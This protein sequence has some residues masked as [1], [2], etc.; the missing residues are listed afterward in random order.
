SLQRAL[1]RR[2]SG[3]AGSHSRQLGLL[4][5]RGCRSPMLAGSR[6]GRFRVT[7]NDRLPSPPPPPNRSAANTRYK[8]M[9]DGTADRLGKRVLELEGRQ[10]IS[11]LSLRKPGP[12]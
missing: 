7:G 11:L 12:F 2:R 6:I 1:P 4:P 3:G 10:F 5:G 8:N 9:T